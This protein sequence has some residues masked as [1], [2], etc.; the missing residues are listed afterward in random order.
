MH[1]TWNFITEKHDVSQQTNMKTVAALLLVFSF[2][3]SIHCLESRDV[4]PN[5]TAYALYYEDD[6]CS[7]NPVTIV[8]VYPNVENEFCRATGG[9]TCLSNLFGF[10]SQEDQRADCEIRTFE[11]VDNN[12]IFWNNYEGGNDTQTL[13]TC[14]ASSVFTGCY[15]EYAAT[16]PTFT[17]NTTLIVA[18]DFVGH[19]NYFASETCSEDATAIVARYPVFNNGP[20]FC[21]IPSDQHTGVCSKSNL[22]VML[23]YNVTV[24]GYNKTCLGTPNTYTVDSSCTFTEIEDGGVEDILNYGDC[25]AS[26]VFGGCRF[27][28]SNTYGINPKCEDDSDSSACAELNSFLW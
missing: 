8:P 13:N 7:G 4:A 6:A 28:Y 18:T 16:A 27:R 3:I 15:M 19:L 14:V 9:N 20:L 10:I 22:G 12:T 21:Y 11:P 23:P 17:T 1:K 26:S 25:R 24:P 5:P 2:C